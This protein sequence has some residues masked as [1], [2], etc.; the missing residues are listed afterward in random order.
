MAPPAKELAKILMSHEE[1]PQAK[2]TERKETEFDEFADYEPPL[3]KDLMNKIGCQVCDY[4]FNH[5]GY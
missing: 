1:E 2:R 4:Q 5:K 3:L